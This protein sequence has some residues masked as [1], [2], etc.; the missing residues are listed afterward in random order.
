MA[1]VAIHLCMLF[2]KPEF[3]CIVI[4]LLTHPA[5]LIMAIRTL[6]SETTIVGIIL[7]MTIHTA[8]R[9]LTIFFSRYVTACTSTQNVR[10][11]KSVISAGMIKGFNAHLDNVRITPLVIGMAIIAVGASCL[12]QSVA[13]LLLLHV[14]INLLMTIP[15]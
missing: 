1:A 11:L 14:C 2:K 9:R 7:L 6:F 10:P 3:C 5:T 15:T 8:F 12:T 4:K 13:T